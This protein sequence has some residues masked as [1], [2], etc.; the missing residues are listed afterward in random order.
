MLPVISSLTSANSQ[1]RIKKAYRK[2]ALELHPDRNFGDVENATIKFAEVQSANEVLS[3]PQERAWYDSHRESILRGDNGGE[4]DHFEHNIR[5]TSAGDIIT[6]VSKFNSSVPF[7][8]SPNGFYG[9]L[10]ETFATLAA[11]ERAACEWEGKEAKSYPDFGKA[12]D[13]YE[14][15][16]K[17]FYRVWIGFSTDKT[18]A[19]KDVYRTSDAPDRATRRLI[20]K[21]NK[22][23]RNEG[24]QEFN[25]AVRS[26]VAFVRKRDP[27]YIP[28][29]QSE[30][31]R[32]KILRDAVSA[33]AARSRAANQAKLQ[34]QVLPS[35]AHSK[36]SNED[37]FTESESEES[38]VEHIECVVCDKTFKSEKQYET[39][40]KSKKHI[41][42]V[43]QIQREMKKEN[44]R[45][46]L[47]ALSGTQSNPVSDIENLELDS[48]NEDADTKATTAS[49]EDPDQKP[50]EPLEPETKDDPLASDDIPSKAPE[51]QDK[52]ASPSG[53]SE[54]EDDEYAPR[55]DVENRLDGLAET[56]TPKKAKK[57]TAK[58]P[59][60]EGNSSTPKLG[61][62]KEKRA[63][64]A[65]QEAQQEQEDQEVSS[66]RPSCLNDTYGQQFKCVACS[67]SFTSKNKLF[68]HIKE[69]GHAQPIQK[70]KGKG[71]KK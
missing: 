67:D 37:E 71:K 63:K 65:A 70:A 68:D 64:R 19:W 5:L 7:T 49:A 53:S 41:K 61:K 45:L 31:D 15:S 50:E 30:E 14:Q 44:K 46:G 66:L 21:E 36:D 62:A 40:E 59:T 51:K 12:S 24:I 3:D 1:G 42:A 35:W 47:D 2:K 58:K 55:K 26:L 23:F 13:S 54:V 39:H 57:K 22:R 34:D 17:Q 18:F 29:S 6:L 9:S 4:E 52:L 32:Q 25:D 33:Q 10:R 43:Q 38:E 48:E 16:A 60:S 20:E 8:D 11:E 27:R 28:N 69:F 56:L